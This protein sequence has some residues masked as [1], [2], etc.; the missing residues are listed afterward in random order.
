VSVTKRRETG[1]GGRGRKA[2]RK[3][4]DAL[5][6]LTQQHRPTKKRAESEEAALEQKLTETEKK[7]TTT[8]SRK[9]YCTKSN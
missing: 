7:T 5:R 2:S 6:E 1:K 3:P 4:T 8:Q 9:R